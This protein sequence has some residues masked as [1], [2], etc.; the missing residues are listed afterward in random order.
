MLRSVAIHRGALGRIEGIQRHNRCLGAIG[1]PAQPLQTRPGDA[2]ACYFPNSLSFV[3]PAS[4]ES[5]R[6][7]NPHG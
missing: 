1:K 3:V 2:Q 6:F 5:R 7:E 4:G